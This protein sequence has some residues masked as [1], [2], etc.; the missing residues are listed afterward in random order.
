MRIIEYFADENSTKSKAGKDNGSYT[1]VCIICL[2][3]YLF[4]IKP[5]MMKSQRTIQ[6]Y[7]LILK[8]SASETR[9]RQRML[10]ILMNYLLTLKV[11]VSYMQL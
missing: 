3:I 8:S 6:L 5:K 10:R 1:N 11:H 4:I 9:M 2:F 7:S